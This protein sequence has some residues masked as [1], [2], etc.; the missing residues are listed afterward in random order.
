[1]GRKPRESLAAY[2]ERSSEM[3]VK[4]YEPAISS[5][6]ILRAFPMPP[7]PS[8]SETSRCAAIRVSLDFCGLN[9]H[10][11]TMFFISVASVMVP[12][13]ATHRSRM[14]WGWAF[15]RLLRPMVEYLT[16]PM[17]HSDSYSDDMSRNSEEDAET[18]PS[19]RSGSRSGT[20]MPQASWPRCCRA[21]RASM[22]SG[23][24]L[25][26]PELNIPTT[27]QFSL[28]MVYHPFQ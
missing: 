16:W 13:W 8:I 21:R 11:P 20:A 6:S 4:Q 24:T 7:P 12:L 1:M 18:S 14:R 28:T 25:I 3:N 2:T 15:S 23:T 26:P 22:A 5:L 27:P 9:E 10:P 17:A 19:R